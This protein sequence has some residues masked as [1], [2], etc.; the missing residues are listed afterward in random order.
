MID[1]ERFTA[2]LN[3]KPRILIGSNNAG[4]IVPLK[5]ISYAVDGVQLTR[6][7]LGWTVHGEIEP[8]K[9]GDNL[10]QHVC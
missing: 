6:S 1:E 2:I 4:L 8:T 5:T 3:M 10:E 7:R 9:S